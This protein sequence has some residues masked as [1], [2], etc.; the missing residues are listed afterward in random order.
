MENN[1]LNTIRGWDFSN[2]EILAAKSSNNILLNP[3]I[4]LTGACDLNCHYCF[5][6]NKGNLIQKKRKNNELSLNETIQVIDSF[7]Q[8][9]A[10]TIN[11]VGSGEPTLDIHFKEI[12]E[13]I[14]SKGLTTLLFTNGQNIAK[15]SSLV[16]F[17]YEHDVSV[18]LKMN[19]LIGAKQDLVVGRKGY[20][21]LRDIALN[22][23]IDFGF[24][25]DLITR[26]GVDSTVYKGNYDELPS[27]HHFCRANNIFP[28]S[29]NFIPTGRTLGGKLKDKGN[30]VINELLKPISSQESYRLLRANR[31]IDEMYDIKWAKCLAYFNGGACSQILGLYVD[32]EGNIWPCVAKSIR[33]NHKNLSGLLGNIRKGASIKEVWRNNQY[34][35]TIRANYTGSCPYKNQNLVLQ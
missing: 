14:Y 22:K 4:D 32:I 20:S 29:A 25:N 30:S 28:I 9:N 7:V 24:N 17:L 1:R 8:L 23:L 34:I 16:S 27:I 12:V 2:D 10:K 3:S 11:I 19:S 26:L 21:K 5:N 15:D 13:Y 35:Q 18:V 33:K 6:E 31:E